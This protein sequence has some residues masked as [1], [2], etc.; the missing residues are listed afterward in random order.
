MPQSSA[1]STTVRP[2][3]PATI[4]VDL[5]GTLIA[6]DLLWESL[7]ETLKRHPWRL[8]A[9]PLWLLRGRAYAKQKLADAGPV[10]PKYIPYRDNVLRLIEQL[11]QQGAGRVVLAT[12]SHER[13]V[14]PVAEHLGI[15]DEVLATNDERNLKGARKAEALR[16]RYGDDI[17]YIGDSVADLAVWAKCKAG[18]VVGSPRLAERAAHVTEVR[19]CVATPAA[20]L[21]DYWRALRPHHWSK[22]VLL[23]LPLVLAHRWQP[24]AWLRTLAGMALF[25]LA[26]SAIYVLNDLLDLPSDRKHPWKRQRPFAAGR[27]SIAAGMTMAPLLLLAGI[28]GGVLCLGWRFGVAVAFYCVLSLAYSLMLKRMPLADVFVLTSFYG[29]RIITGALITHTPLSNWFLIFSM[30]FFFSLALAKRYSELHHAHEL[31]KAGNSGRGYRAADQPLLAMMG[32]TSGFAAIIVFSFYTRSPEVSGLYPHPG[33]LMLI[34][35]LMLYW[36]MRVWMRA[37]RGELNEDPVTLALSD[38]MSYTVGVACMFCILLTF[39]WR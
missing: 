22:N 4:C 32:V 24:E 6:T 5:D 13:L 26:A 21:Q 20:N 25:G 37:G 14:Q 27:L 16:Q 3:V 9:L 36:L 38:P 12:A 39:L 28:G 23:L 2:A 7:L 10:D 34:A 18:I 11:R 15:F 31:V 33:A 30:F 19:E 29:I 17:L 1:E 35:P 8:L